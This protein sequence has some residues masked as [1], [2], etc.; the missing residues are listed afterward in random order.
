MFKNLLN[1]AA[2]SGAAGLGIAA[3]APARGPYGPGVGDH[4]RSSGSIAQRNRWTRQ[5]H[6]HRREIARRRRQQERAR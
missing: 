1:A 2:G 6:E 3:F 5:P 4:G